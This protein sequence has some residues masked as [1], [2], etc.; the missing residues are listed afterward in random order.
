MCIENTFN[1]SLH[2]LS[3]FVE[4]SFIAVIC[5]L[6]AVLSK[7]LFQAF[8]GGGRDAGIMKGITNLYGY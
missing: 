4:D 7:V 5:L 8:S 2:R 6:H 3:T 1:L